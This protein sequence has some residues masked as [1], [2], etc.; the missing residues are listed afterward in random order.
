MNTPP[1]IAFY[2]MEQVLAGFG[3][4]AG[5]AAVA[6]LTRHSASADAFATGNFTLG[7][8][9]EGKAGLRQVLFRGMP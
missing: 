8:P 6:R 3:A 2:L 7:R 9:I 4:G 5:T 1:A